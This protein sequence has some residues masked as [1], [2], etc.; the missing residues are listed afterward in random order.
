MKKD[1]NCA[2]IV[3]GK[4][5]VRMLWDPAPSKKYE[6]LTKKGEM[7][8]LCL[9]HYKERFHVLVEIGRFTEEAF[10]LII[11][12]SMKGLEGFKSYTGIEYNKDKKTWDVKEAK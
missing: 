6:H 8:W 2:C 12:N 4:K 3:C 7:H 1:S 5:R 10:N 9:K 11:E